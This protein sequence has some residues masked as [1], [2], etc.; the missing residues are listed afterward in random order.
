MSDKAA[1][2]LVIDDEHEVCQTLKVVFDA[3]G[4]QVLLA[5][6][7]E[8]AWSLLFSGKSPDIIILDFLLPGES[9]PSFHKRLKENERFKNISVIPFTSLL[10]SAGKDF[11]LVRDFVMNRDVMPPTGQRA[12]VPKSLSSEGKPIPS[13]L[14]LA[15]AHALAKMGKPVPTSLRE[16]L[17]KILRNIT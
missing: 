10:E 16:S 14:L 3:F 5:P 7:A 13:G 6:T 4:F 15:V 11:S 2:I 12:I 1:K 8:A 9:G 17:R